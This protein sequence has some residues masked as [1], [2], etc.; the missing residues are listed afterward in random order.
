[1][2]TATTGEFLRSVAF[3][4]GQFVAVGEG[5]AIVTSPD[6]VNW[7]QL[8]CV[9]YASG[10]FIAAGGG[11]F[12]PGLILSATDGLNWTRRLDGLNDWTA[13]PDFRERHVRH[14]RYHRDHSA[15]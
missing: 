6:G 15:I 5:G 10:T 7:T 12:E 1:L 13:G 4:A 9:T 11:L 3:G 14:G 8:W 2:A